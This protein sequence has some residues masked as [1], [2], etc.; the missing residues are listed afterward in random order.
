MTLSPFSRNA[1]LFL[2]LRRCSR[3]AILW[4]ASCDALGRGTV[5]KA[6]TIPLQVVSTPG[7]SW[8]LLA[9]ELLAAALLVASGR[10]PGI[11]LRSLQIFL[12]F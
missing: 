5:R 1:L 3:R 2:H 9:G 10:L 6:L 11:L 7:L 12:R 4:Q 8:A